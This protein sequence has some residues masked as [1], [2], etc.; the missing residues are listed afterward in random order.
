M[1][2]LSWVSVVLIGAG[3]VA[4]IAGL[5]WLGRNLLVWWLLRDLF[6]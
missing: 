2:W 3:V 1:T 4:G 5:L 6:R